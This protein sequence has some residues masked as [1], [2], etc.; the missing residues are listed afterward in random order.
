M[1]FNKT[2]AWVLNIDLQKLFSEKPRNWRWERL[3][4]YEYIAEKILPGGTVIRIYGRK[5]GKK[6]TYAKIE[7]W[8]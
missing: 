5:K 6:L 7:K 4:P 8:V 3:S 2:Y 1:N